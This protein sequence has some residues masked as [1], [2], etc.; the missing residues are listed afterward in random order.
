MFDLRTA[1]G[2]VK[3]DRITIW[4]RKM[5]DDMHRVDKTVVGFRFFNV[6][7]DEKITEKG[8]DFRF[9]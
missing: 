8:L 3:V 1:I 2:I 6:E 5:A 4:G 7:L 9:E